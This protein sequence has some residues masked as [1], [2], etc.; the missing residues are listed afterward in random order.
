[1]SAAS[2]LLEREG[3][4]AQLGALI[5]A[6]REG[7]GRFVLVEG[8][9]G[10]GKTRLLAGAKERGTEAGMHVLH[11]RGGELETEF[12]YGIVRQ[13]FEPALAGAGKAERQDVLSGAAGLAAP[14]F[15]GDYLTDPASGEVDQAFATLH[16][17]FW[18]TA[19]L[20]AGRP[21]LLAIDDLHWADKPSLRWLAYVVRRLEGLPVLA[22]ACVRSVDAGSEESLLAELLSDPAA[23]VVRPTPLSEASVAL[24]V[25]ER[26]SPEAD[27]EFC[28]ACFAATGGNPL[29]V[30]ELIG[31]LESDRISPTAEHAAEVR[32]IGPQGVV[33]SVRTRLS[34]LP[35]EA[36]LLARAVAILGDDVELHHAA[37]V[38]DL[39]REDAVDAAAMLGRTDILRAE[40]P[41]G[42]VHPVVR[43]A[44]Y[45]GLPPAERERGHARAA[46]ILTES[47]APVEQVASQLLLVSPSADALV[48]ATL[49]EAASRS[50]A[51]GAAETS[52]AYLCRALEE[53]PR[54]EER[55]DVL[56]EL[57]SAERLT[58]A[59]GAADHL[60][61]ALVLMKDPRRRGETALELGRMLFW[62]GGRG[63]E[64]AEVFE[65]AIAELADDDPDLRQ[66]LEAG[67]LTIAMEEPAL[68]ART[69]ER[70]ERLRAEPLDDTIGGRI[71]LAA[72]AYH[73]ARAGV[74]LS[75]CVARAEHALSGGLV[76][77]H[78]AGMGWCHAG[79]VLVNSDRFDAAC[80]VYDAA[81][82]DARARGSVFA[83]A[84]ACL[85]RGG[86]AYLR[87]S[88][89]DAEADLRLAIEACESND[90]AAG[91][92][93]P[94]AYL[95]D[96][97]MQRGDLVGAADVLAR[98]SS[99]EDLP[100]TV[101]LVSFRASRAR[102][103]ILQGRKREGLTELLALGRRYEAI[104]GRNP[105]LFSWRSQAALALL[106]LGEREEACRLA[107]EEVELTRQWG[108]PRA[109]GSALRTAGLVEEGEAGLALLRE[110][111]EVLEDSPALLERARALTELGAALRRAN[112]RAEAREPL[113]RGL[114]L[115][116]SCGAK[117][118]A[119][120]AHAEL[121]ATGA[122][123]RRLVLS[124]LDS[125]TPSERRVADMAAKGMT[126][127][128]IAQALFVTPRTVEVHLSN[129]YRKL[130]IGSRSQLPQALDAP[131]EE[132]EQRGASR[133]RRPLIA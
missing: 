104:G 39:D 47:T 92:P 111:V 114:E 57:G 80:R 106:E 59:T 130:G 18:L 61:E 78:E 98:V 52:V 22:I 91:L 17:L 56:H 37:A 76:Y 123:P 38:A 54:P 55:A 131:V 89:A 11:A 77:G 30:R 32:E 116:H 1:L 34:R 27:A 127:R 53:P 110:A 75:S 101:H 108:A 50:L 7:T 86:A 10:I 35:P 94:F 74:S 21:L 113:R 41:L 124:G 118:L 125:L 81:L 87:G 103:W 65:Q 43:A 132:V 63:D 119:E 48:V 25:R 36:T 122:R 14:L 45:S 73:D 82:A 3:E 29:L 31:A 5:D 105:A 115:A 100:D 2:D 117:P 129:T 93:T 109:L 9:A 133:G 19:N 84:L 67:L 23:F 12:P 112:R 62:S 102:L 64:A 83:F 15:G 60:R 69:A 72:L 26:L 107:A 33:R 90:L 51:Q 126:N 24:L 13:L 99:G 66:R 44:V 28:T 96:T 97:L 120:R 16:G 46:A 58:L 79:F 128:D 42:F 70:L 95:A 8:G 88:L 68:Y 4:L 49:R 40:L 6:A 85:L 71:L 20:A 121:I